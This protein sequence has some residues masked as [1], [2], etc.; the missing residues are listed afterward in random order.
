MHPLLPTY[1]IIYVVQADTLGAISVRT[2]KQNSLHLVS[3]DVTTNTI[4]KTTLSHPVGT[5]PL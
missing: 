2:I 1:G 5:T 3:R 4:I